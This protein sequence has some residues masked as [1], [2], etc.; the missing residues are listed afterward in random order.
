MI[1]QSMGA[2]LR[3]LLL[4]FPDIASNFTREDVA[5]IAALADLLDSATLQRAPG[6]RGPHILL[7]SGRF[8]YPDD[9]RPDEFDWADVACGLSR[10]SRFTGQYASSRVPAN[11]TYTVAQHS[12]L[13]WRL[14]LD[15]GETPEICKA[16]ALH[17]AAEALWGFGDIVA[18]V[19]RLP[20]ARAFL[21]PFE[22]KV[23]AAIAAR[24]GLA[25]GFAEWPVV[26]RYD[27]RAF[28]I[29]DYC[30]RG[31]PPPAEFAAEVMRRPTEP[32]SIGV[33]RAML[34]EMFVMIGLD[35]KPVERRA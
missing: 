23:E 14:A 22:R 28:A 26:K 12:V 11:L 25:P 20:W 3:R 7:A 29:E 34:D 18:P 30:L 33:V 35:V 27:A 17:D 13:A 8:W 5:G 2:V 15:D 24:A 4:S 10:I 6:D 21:M 1:D 19:K 31:V 9:P 16:V 32:R